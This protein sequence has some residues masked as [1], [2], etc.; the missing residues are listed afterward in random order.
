VARFSGPPAGSGGNAD[1][2]DITFDGVK[3]IGA[4]EAS[5]DGYGNGTIE[6]V[7]DNEL[8]DNNQY[9]IID[10]TVPSHIHIRAGGTQDDSSAYLYLGAEKTNV[11]V[12]DGAGSVEVSSKPYSDGELVQNINS[13]PGNT[14]SV[15]ADLTYLLDNART[16]TNVVVHDGVRHEITS[17]LVTEG[18]TNIVA[19]DFTFDANGFYGVF[20]DYPSH[21]W[22]FDSDGYLYGPAEGLLPVKGLLGPDGDNDLEI[23]SPTTVVINGQFGEFL[24]SASVATNQI[25]TLGDIGEETVYE[26]QGGTDETQ[27]TFNG[28]PLF[29]A[30]YVRMSS[31]LVHFQIQVDMDNITSFGDGQ[32]YVDLPF[33]AKHSYIFRDACLHDVSNPRQYQLSGHVL[34]GESRMT[35]W[36]PGAGTQD[37]P[38]DYNSPA[39]L[40]VNDSFHIAGTYIAEDL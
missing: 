1:T 35:L 6:L 16:G 15:D 25:A 33:P 23:I 29:S 14:L 22:D 28:D 21:V 38:F 10:P 11:L 36:Y 19:G 20:R 34:A 26:V 39:L 18:V 12:N 5:G 2:G 7:P 31:N 9:L 37:Q 4:G 17:W 24:D 13:E 3:I 8:Y 27:P 40:T 30:S 32:Y